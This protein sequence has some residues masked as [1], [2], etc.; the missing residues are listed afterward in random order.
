MKPLKEKD[1]PSIESSLQDIRTTLNG[2]INKSRFW[3]GLFYVA[4]LTLI[5]FSIAG[6]FLRPVIPIVGI[7]FSL[8][9]ML[10]SIYRHQYWVDQADQLCQFARPME[11]AHIE[12]LN[13]NNINISK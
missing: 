7:V 12:A 8:V 2:Y 10:I 13:S 9:V 6:F 5:L 3:R 1:I 11:I 4:V